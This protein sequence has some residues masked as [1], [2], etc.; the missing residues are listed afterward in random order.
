M[1]E[2]P[3]HGTCDARFAA[4]RDAFA[5]NFARRGEVGAAVAVMLTGRPVVDLWGGAADA[6]RTRAWERDTIVHVFSTTKGLTALCAHMLADRA[7]LDLDAPVADH[8]P[9]FAAAGKATIT[10]RH[11][12]S[13]RA[14]LPAIRRSLPP[15]AI[16]D[17]GTMTA[18]LAA[19]TPWWEPGT[20][21]GYH[22]VTYGWL[23]GEVVRRVSGKSLGTFFRDEVAAPLR[24]DCHIG[25]APVHDARTAETIAGGPPGPDDPLLRALA[26]PGS[27]FLKALSNPPWTPES[28]NTRAWRAAEIPAVNAHTNARAVARLYGV[29]ASGGALDGVRLLGRET[30][31][32]A[33][34]EQCSGPDVVTGLPGRLALGFGLALPEWPLGPAPRAFGHPGA[35][36]S[37]GFADP[38]AALGFAYTPNQMGAGFDLRDPRTVALIDAVYASL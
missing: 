29:L 37:V 11:V 6:A 35:G 38:D 18:A 26:D 3:V 34:E 9:E 16:F 7:L 8:W 5:E 25:L 14:G 17:W 15:E 24:L 10:M 12:L 4:V 27:L 21:H 23:V 13:H 2:V 31:L 20:R 1:S 19:E 36:G 22:L 30:L 28:V 32:R 33:V